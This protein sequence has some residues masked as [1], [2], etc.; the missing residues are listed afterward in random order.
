MLR[1]DE[2][3]KTLMKDLQNSMNDDGMAFNKA[4]DLYAVESKKDRWI[5]DNNEDESDED[6]EDLEYSCKNVWTI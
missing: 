4:L 1:Q 2:L 5:W 6:E 3:Y